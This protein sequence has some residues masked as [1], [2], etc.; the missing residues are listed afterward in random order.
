MYAYD[1]S[2]RA[3]MGHRLYKSSNLHPAGEL[4]NPNY[5][6]VS[7]SIQ[8]L[9]CAWERQRYSGFK[10]VPVGIPLVPSYNSFLV[11]LPAQRGP[12]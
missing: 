7:Y 11:R 9:P 12:F 5:R 3:I 2:R 10:L 1:M 6:N 8:H 4:A